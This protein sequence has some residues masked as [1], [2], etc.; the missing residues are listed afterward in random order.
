LREILHKQITGFDINESALRFAALGLYLMS[1]ELDRNPIPVEKLKFQDLRPKVLRKLGK[2]ESKDLGSLGEEVGPEHDGAYDLVIGNPPWARA[3]GLNDWE[4]IENRVRQ[5][6]RARLQD[7]KAAAPLPGAVVDLPF[8]WRAMEWARPNGQIAF[9]LH[10]RLLFHRRNGMADARSSLFG[11]VEVTGIINGTEL[12]D[13]E[14]WPG[15][16]AP[17]CILFA[18]N[19]TPT[20]GSGFRFV[21]PN[22]DGPLNRNGGWRIDTSFA[23]FVTS[24]EVRNRPEILKILF[25]GTR[26][27]LDLYDRIRNNEFPT[28]EMYWNKGF[29]KKGDR[30]KNSGIGY[31]KIH[32]DTV[33]NKTGD[34]LRGYSSDIIS[35]IP[36]LTD[37]KFQGMVIDANR[38][39]L[40]ETL[41]LPR[42]DRVRTLDLYSG[43][44]LLVKEVPPV[45]HARVRSSVVLDNLVFSQSYHGYSARDYEHGEQ[46]VKYLSLVM[47]SKLLLWYALITSGRFGFEREVIEKYIILETPMKPFEDLSIAN[48]NVALG[49]FDDLLENDCEYN[50]NRV[51][52]WVGSLYG[53]SEENIET[54]SDT[55][56]YHLP[57]KRNQ[58]IA[59]Q[60]VGFE[61][62][63]IFRDRLEDELRPWSIR[64]DR[65][66]SVENIESPSMSPWK[67][68]RIR[69]GRKKRNFSMSIDLD[70]ELF[71]RLA[72]HLSSVDF[73]YIDDASDSIILARLNQ[74]RYW[75]ATQARLVAR[76]IIWE[77]VDF[78]SNKK[79]K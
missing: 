17:F 68:V 35:N 42:L 70:T 59:Q 55:L 66:I 15:I 21:S 27:D 79:S 10:A 54:I 24:E 11:S 7:E 51:D 53:L 3:T 14:V 29:E 37:K 73:V 2:E 32:R 20:A 39:P 23:E 72:D 74:A 4:W 19:N 61:L 50:W 22:L 75:S 78:L 52:K 62:A 40:F 33:L 49:L 47:G 18:R 25:R 65:P 67:F 36:V 41:N 56:E 38:Y 16:S 26:L 57:F 8:V 46:L 44:L 60:P 48:K 63:N 71:E 28:F 12:R 31:K 30:L 34:G 76:R 45:K 9:A 1:I 13:T 69:A 43:P 77:Q 58:K 6:A 64:F 5:I